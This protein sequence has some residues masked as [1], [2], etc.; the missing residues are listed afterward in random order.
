MYQKFLKI[1]KCLKEKISV[2]EVIY[3][4]LGLEAK[5]FEFV[6]RF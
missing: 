6:V 5:S 2:E 1:E 3:V 4:F